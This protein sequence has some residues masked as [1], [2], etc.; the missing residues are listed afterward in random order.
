MARPFFTRSFF[1]SRGKKQQREKDQQQAYQAGPPGVGRELSFLK[2]GDDEWQ[3]ER[4]RQHKEVMDQYWRNKDHLSRKRRHAARELKQDL[5][6]EGEEIEKY[7]RLHKLKVG[8]PR[9][10]RAQRMA[11]HKHKLLERKLERKHREQWQRQLRSLQSTRDREKRRIT[12]EMKIASRRA[13][14][15]PD[16]TQWPWSM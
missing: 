1:T 3:V 11:R 6:R 16:K 14:G 7:Y 15:L 5:R 12:R 4:N 2:S 9:L 13:R 10:K 8:D